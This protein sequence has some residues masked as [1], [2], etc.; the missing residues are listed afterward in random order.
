MLRVVRVASTNGY[1]SCSVHCTGVFFGSD[2]ITVTKKE[3]ET[4][5]VLKPGVFAAIMDHY[6]SGE[7]LFTDKQTLE[8][9]DTAIRP[10]DD[11]VR[12][13]APALACA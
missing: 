6:A 5:A 9:S 10:E 12:A 3:E 2:F 8:A 11:E 7:P 4:W 13:G 1:Q